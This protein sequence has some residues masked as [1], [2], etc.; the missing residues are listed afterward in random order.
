MRSASTAQALVLPALL[1]VTEKLGQLDSRPTIIF[2]STEK[3]FNI[4]GQRR[5]TSVA[6]GDRAVLI[7]PRGWV[8]HYLR[9]EL[10]HVAQY[11]K[12]GLLRAWRAPQWL[13]EGMV[14]SLSDDPRRPLPGELEALR[15]EYERRLG[16]EKR[17]GA[18]DQGAAGS[19]ALRSMSPPRISSG[20][21]PYG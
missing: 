19:R 6:F 5:S 4:F 21:L 1:D 15:V 8:N 13:M 2:C 17:G 12:L 14:Y 18:L 3:C 11:Q 7:G 20:R 10:I 16:G 9:H